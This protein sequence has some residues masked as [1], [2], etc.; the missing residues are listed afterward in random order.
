MRFHN[1]P[2]M[3]II[4]IHRVRLMGYNSRFPLHYHSLVCNKNSYFFVEVK[5]LLRKDLIKI[6]FG[7]RNLLPGLKVGVKYDQISMSLN[8]KSKI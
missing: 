2:T 6:C 8:I 7:D 1:S 4:N 5:P 3:G